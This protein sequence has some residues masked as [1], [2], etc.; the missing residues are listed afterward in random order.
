MKTFR[1][2]LIWQ[3]AMALVTQTYAVTSN[4]PKEELFGLTSEIR[5][6]SIAI[7][8]L[9]AEGSGSGTNNGFYK[10]LTVVVSSLFAFQTQIEIAVNLQYIPEAEFHVLSENS[11]ELERMISSFMSKI[12]ETL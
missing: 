12:K 5:K 3:K 10:S 7:P 8:S 9:I 6:Y 2:L 4:F 1:D 11:R